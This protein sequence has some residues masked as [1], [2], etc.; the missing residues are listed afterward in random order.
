M[1]K[2]PKVSIVIPVYKGKEYMK[3]AIDSALNQSYKNIEIIVVNDGSEDN[4]ATRNI[5]LSYGNKIRYFEKE[6]GGVSTALN[7]AIKNMTGDYFSWLSHD[8]RYY[9]NKIADQIELLKKYDSNTILYSDY[10]LMDENSNVFANSIKNHDELTN[11][12]EYALLRGAI[13]GITL[14][15]PKEA[16]EE[17][18]LFREDLRCT[19]DYELWSRMMKKYKF[20][21]EP[22]ILA[23]TRLHKNQTGN[24]SPRVAVENN[25]LWLDLIESISDKRKIELEKSIYNY[26]FQMREF[27][28]TTNFDKVLENLNNKISILDEEVKNEEESILVSVIIPFYKNI[29]ELKRAIN[30][31]VKQTHK[32]LEIIVIDDGNNKKLNIESHD[33]QN[34]KLIKNKTNMGASYSRNVGIKN[35]KGQYI[36]F[37]D[38]D[39]EFMPEKIE[40]QLI[41]M[42][43]NNTDFSFTS[44][45]RKSTSEISIDCSC[46]PKFLKLKCISNCNIA[47]PT[48]MI[49]KELLE[50][51]N[52]RYDENIKYGEDVIFYLNNFKY[53]EPICLNEHLTI[54]NTN[55]NSAYLD[56]EKQIEGTKNILTYI[57]N[58][59]EYKS[60]N[61]E[62]AKLCYGLYTFIKP[63]MNEFNQ[64]QNNNEDLQNTQYIKQSRIKKYYNTLKNKG[65]GYCIKRFFK[66]MKGK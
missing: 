64:V 26:Y 37:L 49:K 5:A 19:Q 48:V 52:L 63:D 28:K 2:N 58:D 34:I 51:H 41:F 29:N 59:D 53:T 22:G 6:N 35:A 50:K 11:K 57:L 54:V 47:T 3:E 14:L 46:N 12:P 61:N 32:K 56:I 39:D 15:I 13:N 66:K 23:T 44:Y 40:K 9:K 43:K 60:Q 20:I 7:L 30:S 55:D 33:F 21:H 38:S 24:I 25:E 27:I 62:I 4:N 17:C 16:F 1:K 31:I 10:D 8:D 42:I 65:L 18:G 45:I 36:A